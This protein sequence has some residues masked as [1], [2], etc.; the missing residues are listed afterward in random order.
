MY[1]YA[2]AGVS[3]LDPTGSVATTYST[4]PAGGPT[5]VVKVN[6]SGVRLLIVSEALPN[7]ADVELAKSC[8]LYTSN[9]SAETPASA[10]TYIGLANY[11]PVTPFR[12]LDTR[13]TGGPIGQGLVRALQVTGVGALPIPASATAAVLNVTEVNGS[14][15]SLLTVYPFNAPRPTASNLNFG[16]STVIANLVTVT[17]GANA[18]QGWI[19]IYNSIGLSLIHIYCMRIRELGHRVLCTPLAEMTWGDAAR[20]VEV[21]GGGE[22]A[23]IFAARWGNV[24]EIDDPY[25]NVN[26]L[27]PTPLSLR[28]D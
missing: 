5:G 11:A 15:S 8:L 20:V 14:A 16:P 12:I 28:L 2:D 21:E 23:R 18:G 10:Y 9:P 24:G 22:D 26:V 3:A 13:N 1:R 25:L 4:P 7:F 27:W 17:L 6:E 19:N